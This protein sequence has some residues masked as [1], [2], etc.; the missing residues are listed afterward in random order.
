MDTKSDIL[1]LSGVV[2]FCSDCGAE[3]IFVPV[4]C[5][6]PGC[7]FCCTACDAAVFL[8]DVEQSQQRLVAL[9]G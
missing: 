3:A 8:V 9:A 7:E 6:A 4:D 1:M 2:A 5:D